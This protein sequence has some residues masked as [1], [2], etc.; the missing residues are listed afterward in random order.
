[1]Y[2]YDADANE[3]EECLLNA[4]KSNEKSIDLGN[5][6][7][8][9]S[10]VECVLRHLK[11]F[12][13]IE[14]ITWSGASEVETLYILKETKEIIAHLNQNKERFRELKKRIAQK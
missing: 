5:F 4:L 1:M 11:H 12:P 7:F 14:E 3:L 8:N 6:E 13:N 9:V 2:H 10:L